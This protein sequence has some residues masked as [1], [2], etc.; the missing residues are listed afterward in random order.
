MKKT[1][2]VAA[3]PLASYAATVSGNVDVY[4]E[5][6]PAIAMTIT[7][8]NDGGSAPYATPG[9]TGV[10]V[11]SENATLPIDGHNTGTEY[12]SASLQVSSSYVAL[13]PNHADNTTATSTIKVFTNDGGYTLS[14]EAAGANLVHT[15]DTDTDT[16]TPIATAGT[17]PTVSTNEG[18]GFKVTKDSGSGAVVNESATSGPNYL[19]WIA[20]PTTADDI[21]T[22]SAKT[23]S[24]DQYTVNYGVAI[25]EKPT[26]IYS[27]TITYTATTTN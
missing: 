2:G 5:V 17:A 26:G 21:A 6:E 9:T 10:D 15:N 25:G 22:S 4:V 23:S 27:Q 18:W 1:S 19:N 24:G 16:I 20:V 11:F 14:A 3:L 8:N 12:D 7:G 13:L